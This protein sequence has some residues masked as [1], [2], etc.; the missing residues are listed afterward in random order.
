MSVAKQSRTEGGLT[1]TFDLPRTSSTGW[2]RREEMDKFPAE[3]SWEAIHQDWNRKQQQ[4][5]CHPWPTCLNDIVSCKWEPSYEAYREQ[6][7]K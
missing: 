3:G 1:T 7:A 6:L 4:T 2:D 5:P